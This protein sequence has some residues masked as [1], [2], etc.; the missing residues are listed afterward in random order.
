MT[1]IAVI[2]FALFL[3]ASPLLAQRVDDEAAYRRIETQ[4]DATRFD[5]FMYED[6]DVTDVVKD[7][8]RRCRV[9]IL[10]ERKT[11]EAL[12]E[13]D[14]KITIELVDIKAVNALNILL[15]QLKL[16]RYFR[17]GILYIGTEEKAAEVTFTRTYDVRDV[18]NKVRDFPAPKL[19]L[20]GK[21]DGGGVQIRIPEERNDVDTEDI[22]EIIEDT[23]D[24]DWGGTASI[25]IIRGV[26][27]VT[28]TRETHKEVRALIRQLRT[29]R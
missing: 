18:T 15:S 22:V 1:R 16:K 27:V 4:L 6:A 12:S 28:A 26:L 7:I 11:L 20:R 21:E 8:A 2:A 5:T 17:D 25:Q 10:F 3:V 29:T 24:A 23:V 19:R 14:R 13:D 9:T